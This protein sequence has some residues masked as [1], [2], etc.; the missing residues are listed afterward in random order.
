[1]LQEIDH[2]H[3]EEVIKELSEGDAEMERIEI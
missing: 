2:W 3:S 1:M